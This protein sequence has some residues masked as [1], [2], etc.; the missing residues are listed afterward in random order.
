[1]NEPIK[2]VI[3]QDPQLAHCVRSGCQIVRPL[4]QRSSQSER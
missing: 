2:A 4:S 3:R 1:M